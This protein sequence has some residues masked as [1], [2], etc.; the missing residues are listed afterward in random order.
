MDMLR[1]KLLDLC[2]ENAQLRDRI[3][4]LEEQLRELLDEIDRLRDN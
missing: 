1:N 4:E 2:R 3:K